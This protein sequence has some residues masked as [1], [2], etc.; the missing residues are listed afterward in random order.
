MSSCS[1]SFRRS[2]PALALL[3]L[4]ATAA[5]EPAGSRE[6]QLKWA[7]ATLG[8]G[9]LFR[10]QKAIGLLGEL[11]ALEADHL[12]VQQFLKL[13]EGTL[14]LGLW[15]EVLEAAAKRGTPAWK[16][17]LTAR[18]QRL[19]AEKDP[20]RRFRECLEGGDAVAGEAVFAE[21][22]Q[23][24][25]IR[26]HTISGKGGAIGPDLTDL[27]QRSDRIATLESI[28]LPSAV[29]LMGYDQVMLTLRSGEVL[30]GIRSFESRDEVEITSVIDGT[31]KRVP[32]REIVETTGLPSAMP[33]GYGEVLSRRA[34][35]DLVEY[36]SAPR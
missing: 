16:A 6:A 30:S 2:K 29:I 13:E 9:S 22:P 20:L 19:A 7:A 10:Q 15:L 28:V 31:K 11:P 3:L 35:R 18:E 8:K 23:A 25:C 36:L 33:P 26:C 24:G 27:G 32:A 5:A 1:I 21:L 12:L 17:R 14:P 4:V 34:L